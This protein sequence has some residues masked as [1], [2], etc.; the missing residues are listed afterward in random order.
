MKKII[1]FIFII[2][3]FIGYS[4][5]DVNKIPKNEESKQVNIDEEK[6]AINKVFSEF[7]AAEAYCDITTANKLITEDSKKVVKFTCANMD[8]EQKCYQ[9]RLFKIN[10]KG[11]QGVLYIDPFNQEKENPF[12]FTRE[13]DEWK[14]DFKR[15]SEGLVMKGNKCDSGWDWRNTDL[16]DEFCTYFKK[17]KCPI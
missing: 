15:M 3:L 13:N 14:I 5:F 7:I 8:A 12:F 6:I 9:E 2:L 17:D 10:Y 16:R 1:L 4:F 11:N